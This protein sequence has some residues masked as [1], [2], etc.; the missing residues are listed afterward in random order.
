MGFPL[1]ICKMH[2]GSQTLSAPN[3][4]N[5]R[6]GLLKSGCGKTPGPGMQVEEAT[7]TGH[8]VRTKAYRQPELGIQAR[9]GVWVRKPV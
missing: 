4:E 9:T 7:P 6:P 1:P 8:T 3:R 2:R 5:Q